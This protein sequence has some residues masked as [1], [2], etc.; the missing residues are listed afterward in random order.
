MAKKETNVSQW[1]DE[2]LASLNAGGGW[3]P[4]AAEGLA[5]L[6]DRRR[7]ARR[8]T[9]EWI[10]AGI[11]S[12][13]A[14]IAL[15][16]LTSPG[17][18]ARPNGCTGE[19]IHSST[20]AAAPLAPA[21]STPAPPPAALPAQAPA[22]KAMPVKTSQAAVNFKETGRAGAPIVCEIYTDYECPSCALLYKDSIPVLMQDYVKTGKMKLLHRDF[23]LPQHPYAR[24]AT[25]YANAAGSL[26]FYDA[27]V[28]QIFRTQTVW[29]KDGN[30][31][32]QVMLVV[33]PSA[34]QKVRDLVANDPHLDDSVVE[35]MKMGASDHVDSTPTLVFVVGGKRQ[36]LT[37]VPKMP[38]L[39]TYLDQVLKGK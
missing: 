35:D 26:G 8:R 9:I 36:S 20:P 39:R 22:V 19:P 14:C 13:A 11:A 28:N 24:L 6:R 2:R 12:A 1:V 33:P 32:S 7:L 25:R 34:M 30:V 27:V 18:C 3:Q 16:V 5:R 37:G 15:M 38:I 10:T 4:D 29:S 17:A 23:P 31:D 21:A